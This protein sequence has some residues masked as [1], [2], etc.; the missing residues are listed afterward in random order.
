M[1]RLR[2]TLALAML[3]G[4]ITQA[5]AIPPGDAEA[6]ESKAQPCMSCHAPE[7]DN[8]AFPRIAGQYAD[9]LYHSLRAYQSG[10]RE[11]PVMGGQVEGLSDRD[12]ADLATYFS[13]LD[14]E[15]RTVS[16]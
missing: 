10:D 4:I 1:R 15:L 9:Y 8:P 5:G 14:S 16:R 12:M 2:R 13:T 3:L 7:L 11:D 6:G